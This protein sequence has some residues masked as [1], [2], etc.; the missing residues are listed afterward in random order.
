MNVVIARTIPDEEGN[1]NYVGIFVYEDE[2]DLFWT[3]D[4]ELNPFDCEFADLYPS[5]GM[6]FDRERD[7]CEGLDEDDEVYISGPT[8]PRFSEIL[9]ELAG[10]EDNQE[11]E[12]WPLSITMADVYEELQERK[13][14]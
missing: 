14:S 9:T 6:F 3:V 7:L 8:K 10:W 2:V 1:W 12:W 13:A 4:E 11:T 5:M